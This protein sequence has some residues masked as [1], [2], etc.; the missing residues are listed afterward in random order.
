M[1]LLPRQFVNST[2]WDESVRIGIDATSLPGHYAGAGRYILGLIH[3]LAAGKA[4]K[5]EYVI[6][7]KE[8]DRTLFTDL[9]ENFELSTIPNLSR[10]RRLAWQMW[11]LKTQLERDGID[12][13]HATHYVV[14]LVKL[15]IP[16]VVTVHDLAFFHFPEF[17]DQRK[18]YFFRWM[19]RKALKV[20]DSVVAVSNST[21]KDIKKLFPDSK[22]CRVIY[23]GVDRLFFTPK[24]GQ[25]PP[26]GKAYILSVGTH[27]RRKN[28]PFLV[29]LFAQLAQRFPDLDLILIGKPENDTPAIRTSIAKHG[30]QGRVLCPGYVSDQKLLQFYQHAHLICQPAH[31]EGFG[32]P[33]LEALAC[34]IPVLIS[35]RPSLNE[36]GA[37][38]VFKAPC[39]RRED[40]L[41]SISGLLQNPPGPQQREIAR[42]YAR[43]FSWEETGKQMESLFEQV[44]AE[45]NGKFIS[46]TPVQ[47]ALRA[48]P[49]VPASFSSLEFAIIKTLAFAQ[50]FEYPLKSNELFDGL[51][52]Y[53][54]G[55]S[56]F[57]AALGQLLQF[58]AIQKTGPYYHLP[59]KDHLVPIRRQREK[60][61]RGLL[62]KYRRWLKFVAYFP[63]VDSVSISGA[64]AF[65]NCKKNDDIDLF[66]I[67]QPKRLWSTYL[68]LAFILKMFN[69]R[70]MICLNYLIAK[71]AHEPIRP[72]LYTAHQIAHLRPFYHAKGLMDYQR[73]H[74]WVR[75]FLPQGGASSPVCIF[76]ARPNSL[77]KM[78][79]KIIRLPL[80]DLVEALAFRLYRQ[81][82]LAKTRNLPNQESIAVNEEVIKLFTHDHFSTIMD[83]YQNE[84][85][86]CMAFFPAAL[87]TEI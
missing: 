80:F 64:A 6:Y 68:M 18:L 58:G 87:K 17:Y 8:R 48:T 43:Q 34:G 84:L 9:P 16:I 10:P 39:N 11:Q 65:G 53:P 22:N 69:K 49:R 26:T 61:T 14:P 78:L 23:S 30:L 32:F 72:H 47:L 77:C 13:W 73:Q 45:R 66:I 7:C 20:A 46:A 33:V 2:Y 76:P 42:N 74:A 55:R 57:N 40:W 41:Q 44:H 29:D 56:Q 63:G 25:T 12:V 62:K 28:L 75:N 86:Q 1:F 60:Q 70:Q 36:I 59:Q 37:H 19:I 81:R 27:E 52:E 50:I 67:T 79:K 71:N 85:E 35:D 54:C 3:G 82:I 38:Y 31:Y 51:L 83:K 21:L 4:K 15:H 5:N 24:N